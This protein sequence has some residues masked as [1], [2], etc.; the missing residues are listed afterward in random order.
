MSL[1]ITWGGAIGV[2]AI[3]GIIAAVLLPSYADYT[4]R[5]QASEAI[6][7]MGAARTPLAEYFANERKWPK[8]L[9]ELKLDTRSKHTESVVISKGAGGTG[10]LELTATLRPTADRRVAGTSVRYWT[11]DG[12]M[13]WTCGPGTMEERN[14]P[15]SCRTGK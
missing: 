13:N 8:S 11:R 4:H 5:S 6:L 10:E 12:G 3:V 7:L 9:E 15:S 2:A 14:L 1:K